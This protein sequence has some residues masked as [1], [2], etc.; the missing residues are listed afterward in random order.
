MAKDTN[1]KMVGPWKGMDLYDIDPSP[2]TYWLGLNVDTSS[3]RLE[4]RPPMKSVV[5]GI[6]PAQ[7]Y[8]IE[9]P[10]IPRVLLAVGPIVPVTHVGSTP[11]PAYVRTYD[12]ESLTALD[13]AINLRTQFGEPNVT[14]DWRCSF[15]EAT[16][17]ESG[18]TRVVVL[19]ITAYCTYVYDPLKGLSA[20]RRLS[21][22][23]DSIQINGVNFSYW[24]SIPHGTITCTHQGRVYYAGFREGDSITLDNPLAEFQSDVDEDLLNADRSRLALSPALLAWSDESDPAGIRADHYFRV[25]QGDSVTGLISSGGVLLVFTRMAIYAMSGYSD[26]TYTLQKLASGIGCVAPGSVV[27]VGA[28]VYF[29]SADGIYGFGGVMDPQVIKLSGGIDPLWTGWRNV[30]SYIPD[31]MATRLAALGFPWRT[32]PNDLYRTNGKYHRGSNQIW[33]SLPVDSGY[34][35]HAYAITA[36][37]DL[38]T[39]GFNLYCQSP[40]AGN[41]PRASCMYDAVWVDE[42]QRWVTSSAQGTLQVQ[43]VGLTDGLADA[44]DCGVPFY[45]ISGRV[46]GLNNDNLQIDAVLVKLLNTGDWV[47]GQGGTPVTVGSTAVARDV[48][49]LTVEGEEAL[50]DNENDLGTAITDYSKR[51]TVTKALPC[52][53]NRGSLYVTG[54]AVTGT[55]KTT[56]LGFFTSRLGATMT[57][58]A[59]RIGVCDDSY[60]VITR[61]PAVR[62]LGIELMLQSTGTPSR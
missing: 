33:W 24:D 52:T 32:V 31:A 34:A 17:S 53:P 4:P 10:G 58:K 16:L 36:V 9:R 28:V 5:S 3:G 8:V 13:N 21:T 37:L 35:S 1:P 47:T 41:Q 22:A 23:T 14:R 60:T 39:M 40:R 38:T 49:F 61:P 12:P 29:M 25:E 30:P 48:P 51:R 26:A 18:V 46:G 2:N 44:N 59:I 7:L 43:D 19:I 45:W 15:E 57:S 42:S 50:H 20:L 6:G 54:A 11:Q 55:A 27:Q 56:S 62:I